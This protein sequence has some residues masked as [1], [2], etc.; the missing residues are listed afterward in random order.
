MRRWPAHSLKRALGSTDGKSDDQ[1]CV[2]PSSST[3]PVPTRASIC[4]CTPPASSPLGARARRQPSGRHDLRQPPVRAGDAEH[5][6]KPRLSGHQHPV[7]P[8]PEAPTGVYHTYHFG[9]DAALWNTALASGVPRA[10][11]TG[12]ALKVS[13]EGCAQPAS[14]GLPPLTQIHLQDITPLPGGGAQVN[15]TSQ[16]FDIPVCGR[17]GASGSTVTTYEPINLCVSAGDYVDLNEEGGFV[18]HIY[19]NG[20]PYQVLGAVSGSTADSFIKGNETGNGATMSSSESTNMDGFV[21]NQNEEL[22][23]RVTLGTGPNATHICAGGTWGLPPRLAPIRVSPQTD[24]VNIR[25]I[26]AVAVF[27]RLTPECKGVVT[28]TAIGKQARNASYGR[29][30]F[31]VPGKTTTHV[32][33]RVTSAMMAL[34]HSY[35]GVSAMLS[36]VVAGKTVTQTI[37]VKIL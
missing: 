15:L 19:Q 1:Q 2:D 6:C 36:A 14:D 32:P 12:Q 18:E 5:R 25:R 21:A 7:P 23:L 11:A 31:S 20:V 35:G 30:S 17:S 8:S 33:I 34:I 29:T 9:A 13:L 24:G 26:V 4:R 27:C 3:R 28:L 37:V 10:P 22:M 16:P